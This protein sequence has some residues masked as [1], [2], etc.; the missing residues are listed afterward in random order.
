MT[1]LSPISALVIRAQMARHGLLSGQAG[2][3]EDP[4]SGRIINSRTHPDTIASAWAFLGWLE[5]ELS[6]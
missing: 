2:F 5:R 6:K 1:G 3:Y 4:D